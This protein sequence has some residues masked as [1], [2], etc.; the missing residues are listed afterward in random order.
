MPCLAQQQTVFDVG[1]QSQLF[2]DQLLVHTAEGVSYTLHPARKHRRGPLLKADQPWEGWQIQLYGSVLFDEDERL[3]KM[4]YTSQPGNS[5]DREMTCYATSKDGLTWEKP[6]VGTQKSRTKGPHNVVADCLLASVFKDR[7]DP[8]PQRR[9]KMVCYVYDRGYLGQVSPDGL[10]WQEADREPI[11]PISYVDDVITAMWDRR[12]EQYVAFPKQMTPVLGR[13]RRSL[14]ISTSRD[15]RHW[16]KPTPAFLADRRD[17]LGVLPRLAAVQP[18]LNFPVNPHVARTEF[19]GTG[20]FVAECGV[21]AFPWVMTVSANVPVYGNQDGPIEVQLAISRDLETWSRPLRGAI[22]PLGSKGAWDCGM[23]FTAASAIQ[24]GDEV[25]LYYGGTNY[26]HGVPD[27]YATPPKGAGTKYTGAIGLATWQRDRFVSVDGPAEGG[28][29]TTVPVK[30][31]GKQLEINAV[32]RRRGK[33][34]VELLDMAGERMAGLP[35]SDAFCGDDLRHR[36]TF[37]GE[38]DI[39]RLAGRP[40]SLRF[41]LWDAELYSF[42]FRE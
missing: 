28:M 22:V 11:V 37:G 16:S 6:P 32:T 9:Y 19:Y 25:R 2:I 5:F 21:I 10:H 31:R 18:L 20:A 23:V 27:L 7:R 14:Y 38:A 41:R 3:F 40:V 24:V 30:F 12:T 4:W 29:V 8:D 42:A 33:I 1:K 39:A 13:S 34:V 15:F 26:T 36:V 17:D 35:A